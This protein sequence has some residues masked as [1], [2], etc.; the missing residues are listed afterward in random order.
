[1]QA[2]PKIAGGSF[3]VR[4]T[5]SF[6]RR[7]L[8]AIARERAILQ[9]RTWAALMLSGITSSVSPRSS[10]VIVFSAAGLAPLANCWQ[11]LRQRILDP[12]RPELHY[13]RG[14]GPKWR[15]KHSH[16]PSVLSVSRLR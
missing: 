15:E 11:R 7:N 5:C 1:M 4:A 14:P 2:K 12:Y 3:L 16:V 8:Q 6:W 10:T 9:R 13:M